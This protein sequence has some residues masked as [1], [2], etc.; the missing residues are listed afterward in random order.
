MVAVITAID[1]PSI[2]STLGVHVYLGHPAYEVYK[3]SFFFPFALALL[4]LSLILLTV[5]I[6]NA[7][8]SAPMHKS[9]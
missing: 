7:S 1:V 8:S 2:R 5:W 6:S 9:W 3:D 4:G